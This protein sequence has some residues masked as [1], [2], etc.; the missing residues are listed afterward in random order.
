MAQPQTKFDYPRK[1]VLESAPPDD[2]GHQGSYT[3]PQ[4][5]LMIE[6]ANTGQR[7]AGPP[8]Q[9]TNDFPRERTSAPLSGLVFIV[10][11]LVIGMLLALWVTW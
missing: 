1:D 8:L 5:L 7:A 6:P 2:G 3:R 10:A 9:Y 4:D 11:A